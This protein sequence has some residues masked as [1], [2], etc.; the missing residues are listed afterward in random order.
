ME[1]DWLDALIKRLAVGEDCVL[2]TVART[3]GSTPREA[4][5]TMIVGQNDISATIGGGHLE[6]QAIHLAHKLLQDNSCHPQVSRFNLGARLGQCCGGVVWL[7]FEQIPASSLPQWLEF[8]DTVERNETLHRQLDSTRQASIWSNTTAPGHETMLSGDLE[9]WCFSQKVS[10]TRFPVF[11]FGAGHVAQ[12]LVRQLKLL[13]ARM[14]WIDTREDAF[15][16]FATAGIHAFVT[17]TP[18]SEV[19]GA[20][21]GTYFLVMTHSHTLDFSLCEQIYTRRDFAYFGLIG[22]RSKRLSFEHRLVDRGLPPDRLSELTCPI[23]IPGIVSKEP[24]AIALSVA[25]Q[26]FQI[27]STRQLL[28]QAGRP[29][30]INAQ[31]LPE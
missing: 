23:G 7:L 15:A 8:R 2:V 20:P 28:S 30:L 13:G 31:T 27:H 21:A 24:Q 9:Y 3:Q 25:A 11:I 10:A 17:D 5:A 14:S 12:A 1:T 16:G 29:C 18:E 19:A 6:W 4:G 26:I 22:S